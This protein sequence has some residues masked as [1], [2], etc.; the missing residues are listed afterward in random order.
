MRHTILLAL[1]ILTGCSMQVPAP[2]PAPPATVAKAIS[3]SQRKP[4]NNPKQKLR[5]APRTDAEDD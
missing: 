2:K 5:P 3:A 4:A 1:V